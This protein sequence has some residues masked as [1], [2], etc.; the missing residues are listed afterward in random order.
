MTTPHN[1]PHAP[2][3]P[4]RRSTSRRLPRITLRDL[5]ALPP[6]PQG[7]PPT[8]PLCSATMALCTATHGPTAG[9]WFWACTEQSRH[10]CR[11][12]RSFEG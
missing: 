7:P 1:T 12:I 5:A 4:R 11:G 6:E 3:P 10:P 8:C 2:L 9:H